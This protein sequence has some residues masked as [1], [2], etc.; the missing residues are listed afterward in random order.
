MENLPK[1]KAVN[2]K[3]SYTLPSSTL[4]SIELFTSKTCNNTKPYTHGSYQPS[5]LKSSSGLSPAINVDMAT[6]AG[7]QR[8][9][10]KRGRKRRVPLTG[11]A[12]AMAVI[13]RRGRRRRAPLPVAIRARTSKIRVIPAR[14]HQEETL[15]GHTLPRQRGCH[16][17]RHSRQGTHLI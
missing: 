1:L 17:R 11:A 10:S 9:S 6:L 2:N 4:T 5:P 7:R 12:K 15:E 3:Q 14:L 16:R 8:S 13:S